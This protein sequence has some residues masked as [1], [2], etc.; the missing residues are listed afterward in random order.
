MT[1]TVGLSAN[2]AP[3]TK[4]RV[5]DP[6]KKWLEMRIV[7]ADMVV[8]RIRQRDLFKLPLEPS[9]NNSLLISSP[10]HV[11]GQTVELLILRARLL[12]HCTG[13]TRKSIERVTNFIKPFINFCIVLLDFRECSPRGSIESVIF[14]SFLSGSQP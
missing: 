12:V 10:V 11:P 9:V 2:R 4:T 7:N 5:S 6:L 1:T 3:T 13:D 14:A 8:R